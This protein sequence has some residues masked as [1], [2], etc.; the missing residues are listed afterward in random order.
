MECMV[1]MSGVVG[2]TLP[3][4][5][6]AHRQAV[7]LQQ[8]AFS[9]EFSAVC[10]LLSLTGGNADLLYEVSSGKLSSM[11]LLEMRKKEL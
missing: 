8:H 7:R 5:T 2:A 3:G 9:D 6:S 10:S 1:E 11:Q 4:K